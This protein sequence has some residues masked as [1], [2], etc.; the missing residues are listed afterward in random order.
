MSARLFYVVP[1]CLPSLLIN[2]SSDDAFFV[3]H[4]RMRKK[5]RKKNSKGTTR[6]R[7]RAREKN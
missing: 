2:Y 1:F 3:K 5:Q 4:K 7:A 6:A